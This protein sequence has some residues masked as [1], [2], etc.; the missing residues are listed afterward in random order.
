MKYLNSEEYNSIVLA[1][2]S[3]V[4]YRVNGND[5]K[6]QF[7]KTLFN[8]LFTIQESDLLKN[9]SINHPIK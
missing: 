2:H 7:Y 8:K 1:I 3:S 9:E 6:E 5:S 4:D